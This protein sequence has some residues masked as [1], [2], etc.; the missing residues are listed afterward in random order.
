MPRAIRAFISACVVVLM[1]RINVSRYFDCSG[2]CSNSHLV[3]RLQLDTLAAPSG[4]DLPATVVAIGTSFVIV[5]VTDASLIVEF[6]GLLPLTVVQGTW[7]FS[8]EKNP[9]RFILQI[10]ETSD[11]RCSRRARFAPADPHSISGLRLL[12]RKHL[13][14]LHNGTES[15][16][17]RCSLPVYCTCSGND[18]TSLST[19]SGEFGPRN[20]ST[21]TR[22]C[23]TRFRN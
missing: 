8:H 22:R 23:F 11:W 16:P 18:D 19:S 14:A 10:K 4:S 1:I 15:S 6:I 5:L 21:R 20:H 7:S 3:K 17:G 12:H 13:L 9:A 2:T